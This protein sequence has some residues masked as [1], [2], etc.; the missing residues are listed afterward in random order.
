MVSLFLRYLLHGL[1]FVVHIV[2]IEIITKLS[3]FMKEELYKKM[4]GAWFKVFVI[5]INHRTKKAFAS[6][7]FY[8]TLL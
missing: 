1:R 3:L 5:S 2:I 4:G 6:N 7:L 8:T